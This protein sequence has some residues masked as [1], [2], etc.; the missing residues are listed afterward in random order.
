LNL[1]PEI[2][3]TDVDLL[4]EH[5]ENI[6]FSDVSEEGLRF[7]QFWKRISKFHSRCLGDYF[8]TDLTY[9]TDVHFLKLFRLSQ[10]TIE[11]LLHVQNYLASSLS[12]KEEKLVAAEARAVDLQVES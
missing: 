11:Y 6:T 10:L 3:Q 12:E 1:T 2:K 9:F 7:I 5:V 8:L 4:Q